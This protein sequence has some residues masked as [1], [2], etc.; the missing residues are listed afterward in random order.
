MRLDHCRLYIYIYIYIY[1]A[2]IQPRRRDMPAST[3]YKSYTS[4]IA[5]VT[6]DYGGVAFV[7]IECTCAHNRGVY[8]HT[9]VNFPR[10]RSVMFI[11]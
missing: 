2:Y 10:R 5:I 11:L 7:Y 4:Y 3:I 9:Y 8:T 6:P 1:V